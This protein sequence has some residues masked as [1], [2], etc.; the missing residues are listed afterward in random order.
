MPK[1]LIE[2]LGTELVDAKSTIV[3]MQKRRKVLADKEFTKLCSRIQSLPSF[4]RE[5]DWVSVD[6]N[7]WTG[8]ADITIHLALK[9]EIENA[10]IAR[11][12][13][14]ASLATKL[15]KRQSYDKTSLTVRGR[16]VFAARPNIPEVGIRITGYVPQ[17]CHVEYE[18][19]AVPARIEKKAKIVCLPGHSI[20]APDALETITE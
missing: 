19:I 7:W 11:D 3:R 16:L 17:T 20:D 9:P 2:T 5:V 14:R 15:E 18:E 12:L 10:Q 8:S 6:T 1:Q 4:E 13:I